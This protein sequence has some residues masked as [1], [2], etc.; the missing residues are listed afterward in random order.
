MSSSRPGSHGGAGGHNVSSK[1]GDP[2]ER[3]P[4]AVIAGASE[5]FPGRRDRSGPPSPHEAFAA[6]EAAYAGSGGSPTSTDSSLR[7]YD[8]GH[9]GPRGTP[10]PR[11]L[12][13]RSAQEISLRGPVTRRPLV[14][15]ATRSPV[16]FIASAHASG[17][18][19]STAKAPTR[20]KREKARLEERYFSDTWQISTLFLGTCLGT[21]I[22]TNGRESTGSF[23]EEGQGHLQTR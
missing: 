16:S 23:S 5:I 13:S 14:V 2:E 6:F 22:W 11:G 12:A 19:K 9:V 7:R 18:K 21:G 17:S 3:S 8:H 20:H 1:G 15:E 4:P 10:S